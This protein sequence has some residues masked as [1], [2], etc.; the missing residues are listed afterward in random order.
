[1]ALLD[2]LEEMCVLLTTVSAMQNGFLT[3]VVEDCCADEPDAHQQTLDRY[4]FIFDRA[5]VSSIPHRRAGW[6]EDLKR[7]YGRR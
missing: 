7:L 4:A 3:A 2:R 5:T 6:L 1:M